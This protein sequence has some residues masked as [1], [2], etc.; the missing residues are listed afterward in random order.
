MTIIDKIDIF[1]VSAWSSLARAVN[2]TSEMSENP[3]H[4]PVPSAFTGNRLTCH[5]WKYTSKSWS[6]KEIL[7]I[8]HDHVAFLDIYHHCQAKEIT[9]FY[10]KITKN[11]GLFSQHVSFYDFCFSILSV[12]FCIFSW[13]LKLLFSKNLSLLFKDFVLKT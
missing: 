10:I 2:D 6:K 8:K 1:T 9:D 13:L 11:Y 4:S 7:Q 12:L 5:C 3:C